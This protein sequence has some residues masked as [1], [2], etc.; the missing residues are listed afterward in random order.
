MRRAWAAAVLAASMLVTAGAHADETAL[1]ARLDALG[2]VAEGEA[3][4]VHAAQAAIERAATDRARGDEAA[5]V[6]AE[7]IAEA[8]IGLIERRRA[9]VDSETRQ[10][11]AEAERDAMRAR[12]EEA[13]AAAAADARERARLAPPGSTP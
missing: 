8:T 9:R 13:R 2:I 1:R 4:L 3:D 10:R 12:L 6:R 7:H 11:A 5:R